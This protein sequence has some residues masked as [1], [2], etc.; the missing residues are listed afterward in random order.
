MSEQKNNVIVPFIIIAG[1]FSIFG[2]VTWINSVL[3]PFMRVVCELSEMQAYLVATASYISFIVMGMPASFLIQ[4]LG[5]KKGMSL[6]L[7]LMAIGALI[8]I[9]ASFDRTYSLFLTGIFVQGAGMAILQTASNP[10]VTILGPIESAA[11]R[12]SIMGICNKAAGALASII[13]GSA[14]LS[15]INQ[16]QDLLPTL[17][18][19]EKIILL[20]ESASSVVGPYTI[21]AG[22]LV[23]LSILILFAP[24]PNLNMGEDNEDGKEGSEENSSSNGKTSIFQFPHLWLGVLALFSYVG[25][26]VMAIDTI[27]AYGISIGIDGSVASAF[28]S[29]T[30]TGMVIGYVL[31]ILLI[32]NVISQAAMLRFSMILGILLVFGV[33]LTDGMTSIYCVAGLGFANAIVWPAVWPLTL[34]KLGKFTKQGSALLVMA[35]AGGAVI[36]LIYGATFDAQK[37][38]KVEDKVVELRSFIQTTSKTVTGFQSNDLKGISKLTDK[39]DS[40][41]LYSNTGNVNSEE[42]VKYASSAVGELNTVYNNKIG[43]GS[44]FSNS[45]YKKLFSNI[46]EKST[47]YE[48]VKE[49]KTV[50]TF[51]SN[52]PNKELLP[53]VIDSIVN[54]LETAKEQSDKAESKVLLA[55]AIDEYKGV[56]VSA[57][58]GDETRLQI[59]KASKELDEATVSIR[60]SSEEAATFSYIVMLPFYLYILFFAVKG[61]KI[62]LDE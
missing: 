56:K 1:M 12:I 62:G 8:F 6:G 35:I 7:F 20:D 39:L 14:L 32:P 57:Q 55:N 13:L 2:F 24:L 22:V 15:G 9:P 50:Y 51:A 5:Y 40:A 38:S 41:L 25:V 33:L 48:K 52:I 37:L 42:F 49:S 47:S 28:P 21:M 3:I 31:G 19:S 23:L 30:I 10:Y 4:K 54:I 29:Y 27:A 46:D 59:A 16:T 58:S 11:R 43:F 60:A 17:S 61:H 34:N 44:D 36:P 53:D 26:E 45:L 18:E